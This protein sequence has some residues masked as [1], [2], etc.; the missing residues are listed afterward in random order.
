MSDSDKSARRS[1]L[2]KIGI[3]TAGIF[4]TPFIFGSRKHPPNAV[5]LEPGADSNRSQSYSRN[6]QIQLAL[7]GAGKMG[8]GNLRVALEHEGVELVAACDLYDSRLNRCRERFGNHVDTTTDYREILTRE[9]VDA[10]VIATPDHWHNTIAVDALNS[11]KAVYL[12]KPMVQHIEEGYGIIEAAEE[13]SQPVI[14]GSTSTSDIVYRKARELYR[15]GQI[16]ELN[17][18]ESHYDRYSAMGAWQY[19]IPPGASTDNVDWDMFLKDLPEIPFDPKRFF[20]WRNYRDYGTGVAG[21]LFVHL[22]SGIHLVTGSK[23]PERIMSTGGLRFWNDGRDVP[24]MMTGMYDYPETESHPA[25]NLTLRVN[26]ADGSGGG[27]MMRFVGS[28][29]EITIA[30]DQVTLKKARL[31]DRP[32]MSI[33][34]FGSEVREEYREYYEEKYGKEQRPTATQTEVVTYKAPEGYS[35]RYD[36]FDNFFRAIRNGTKLIQDARF[37]LRAAAPAL[38]SNLSYFQNEMINWDPEAMQLV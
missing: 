7:I 21:D 24:D 23:G 6:D 30:G 32:G 17:L 27:R 8:Q 35:S 20:R 13:N 3:A 5:V 16:G 9:D 28:E 37:G 22:F 4:S 26:L 14:V 1:F 29:G 10:V 11:G 33:Y 25:F 19:S 18:V 2:K 34:E 38:A 15:N 12:E 31:P 36:H